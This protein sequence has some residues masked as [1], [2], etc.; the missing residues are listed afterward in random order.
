MLHIDDVI[1]ALGAVSESDNDMGLL[2]KSMRQ[3][4]ILPRA[5]MN[6]G[7]IGIGTLDDLLHAVANRLEEPRLVTT[8]Q[9]YLEE[10]RRALRVNG[11]MPPG[12]TKV[13]GR[14]TCTTIHIASEV[15]TCPSS[16]ADR[17]A[18]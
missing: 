12:A 13:P 17:H 18:G 2:A 14:Q 5:V 15:W 3:Y 4:G 6:G 10:Q 1:S 11:K 9:A 16:K 7:R 8:R